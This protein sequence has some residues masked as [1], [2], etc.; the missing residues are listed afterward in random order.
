VLWSLALSSLVLLPIA[1]TVAIL[2]Y[3]LWDV[4]RLV[5]RTVAYAV[6]T[7]VLVAIFAL[8]NLALQQVLANVTQAGTLAVAASTLAVF[9][10]FQPLRRRIQALVDRRFD[11]TRVDAD[12]VAAAFADRLRGELDL[13][14][15]G[16]ET[17]GAV[18]RTLHPSFAAIWLRSVE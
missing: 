5:S 13:E 7:A 1:A 10:L 8:L 4:D 17:R 2:R 18:E 12:R 14:S 15:I 3:R 11:R 9:A 16:S 6:V